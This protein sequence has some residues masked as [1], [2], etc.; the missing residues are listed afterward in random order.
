M[1]KYEKFPIALTGCRTT[2]VALDCCEYDFVVLS[3]E[4]TH[5]L[6]YADDNYAEI[7]TV[8]KTQNI[9]ALG[10]LLQNMEI[11]SD[12]SWALATLGKD[13]AIV[14]QKA[15]AVYAKNFTMDALFFANRSREVAEVNTLLSA[16][17][18]KCA[19]YCYLEAVIAKNGSRP[20]PTHMLSQIRSLRENIDREGITIASTCLG[21]ERANR[22]SVSR[23]MEAAIA[24]NESIT[25]N[26][27]TPIVSRKAHFLLESGMYADCYFYLGFIARN[28]AIKIESNQKIMKDYMFTINIAMDLTN[29]QSFVSKLSNDLVDS[30]N[31]LLL[32]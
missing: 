12:P 17:W 22:S 13:I 32:R 19:A 20:M 2:D 25:E 16:L 6:L 15:L 10:P 18:L 31:A 28:A 9:H 29:D 5:E 1:T 7:H 4:T 21:L 8:Q 11:L 24:L 26:H 27:T 30:C 23:C 3:E 14:M